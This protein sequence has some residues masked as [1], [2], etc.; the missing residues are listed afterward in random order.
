MHASQPAAIVS[1]GEP[2][3]RLTIF[4]SASDEKPYRHPGTPPQLSD[5]LASSAAAPVAP[6]M[7]YERTMLRYRLSVAFALAALLLAGRASVALAN[8][9]AY[10]NAAFNDPARVDISDISG[11]IAKT[12]PHTDPMDDVRRAL[13]LVLRPIGNLA[14]A[15]ASAIDEI[16]PGA[17]RPRAP[18]AV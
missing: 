9:N 5:F 8:A 11:L 1:C 7:R 10:W 14:P 16:S 18:P 17:H 2:P 13:L 6:K 4:G 15:S 12:V 3:R